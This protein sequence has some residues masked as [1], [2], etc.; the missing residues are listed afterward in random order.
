M[1]FLKYLLFAAITVANVAATPASLSGNILEKRQA[2]LREGT[3]MSNGFYY[4]FWNE[5]SGGT[6]SM[7]DGPGGQY[8]TKWNNIGN[9]VAGKGWKPGSAR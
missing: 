1:A 6:V 9:F 2:T 8:A 7:T 5:K 3:G 4:S